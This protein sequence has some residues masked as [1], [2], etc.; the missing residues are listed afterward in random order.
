VSGLPQLPGEARVGRRHRGPGHAGRGARQGAVLFF[1]IWGIEVMSS[2]VPGFTHAIRTMSPSGSWCWKF[3][4]RYGRLTIDCGRA[5][6]T[7]R[8]TL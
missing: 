1:F 3:T 6:Q 5:H 7:T 4:C 2:M 8:E